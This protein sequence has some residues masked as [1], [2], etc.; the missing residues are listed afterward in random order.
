[1]I[2]QVIPMY[3]IMNRNIPLKNKYNSFN[4]SKNTMTHQ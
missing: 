4:T 3:S 2:A 1:M